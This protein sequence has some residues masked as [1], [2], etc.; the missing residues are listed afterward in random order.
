MIYTS[1]HTIA[2]IWAWADLFLA[3]RDAYSYRHGLSLKTQALIRED[4]LI[5]H[6]AP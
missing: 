1:M 4:R 3:G 2:Q 5:G 6:K